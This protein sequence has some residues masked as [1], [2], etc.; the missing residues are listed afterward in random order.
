MPPCLSGCLCPLCPLCPQY[1]PQCLCE[2]GI[3]VLGH[4][5]TGLCLLFFH[6]SSVIRPFFVRYMLHSIATICYISFDLTS[7][8]QRIRLFGLGRF[9]LSIPVRCDTAF[10]F[11]RWAVAKQTINHICS[12][13]YNF[14]IRSPFYTISSWTEL[15]FITYCEF[16]AFRHEFISS[17]FMPMYN[18]R[19]TGEIAKMV[20]K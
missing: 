7:G 2:F 16:S 8:C 3:L 19:S 9:P 4:Y 12:L 6:F 10:N 5:L 18:F 15:D 17:F 1:V 11:L 20:F 13:Y 14:Q